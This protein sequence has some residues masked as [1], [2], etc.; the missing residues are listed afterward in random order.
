MTLL[1]LTMTL[2]TLLW[3]CKNPSLGRSLVGL[4]M[5]FYDLVVVSEYL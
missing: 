3:L 1:P 5:I 2:I 4:G